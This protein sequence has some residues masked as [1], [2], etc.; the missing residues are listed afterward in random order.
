MLQY[1]KSLTWCAN[2]NFRFRSE[3]RSLYK[4]IVT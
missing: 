2:F 3:T 1:L 4:A